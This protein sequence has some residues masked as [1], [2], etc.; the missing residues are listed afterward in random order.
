M[1]DSLRLRQV[2][3]ILAA[4][5]TDAM[6][7]IYLDHNSTTP[8]FPEVAAAMSECLARG[9]GN[10]SS[11]HAVG[12]AAHDAL[13]E[14]RLRIAG[15][16]DADLTGDRPDRVVFTSGATEANNLAILGIVRAAKCGRIVI[17]SAEHPS[18]TEPAMRLL[19]AGLQVDSASVQSNGTVDAEFFEKLLQKPADLASVL[20]ANHETGVVQPIADLVAI[21]NAAGVP[22]HCDAVQAVGK[23]LI[24]FRGLGLAAMTVSVH[25]TGGPV[26]IGALI[27][28]HDVPLDPLCF[29]G[30]QEGGLRPGTQSVALACGMAKALEIA[31]RDRKSVVGRMT[32]LRERFEA[33]LLAA[34]PGTVIHGTGGVRLPNTT[35]AALGSSDAQKLF[36]R[37]DQAGVCCS[38][39]AACSSESDEWSPTLRAMGIAPA[40]IARTLRF[41][42]GRNT[43]EAEVDEAVRRIAKAVSA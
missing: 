41:S 29:G 30:G 20:L 17:S 43:T 28:R 32:K 23:L 8:I 3:S 13:E 16:L 26:G 27:L 11:A 10:P 22:F 15:I 36:E 37:I 19:D 35:S 1:S 40:V 4:G 12:R 2:G 39:G 6:E 21:S 18:V 25:K 34:C 14:A 33:A 42:L 5:Y 31:E 9:L 38:R 7:P 24:S